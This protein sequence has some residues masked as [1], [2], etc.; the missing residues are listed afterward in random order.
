MSSGSVCF[1]SISL[2][3]LQM[4]QDLTECLESVDWLQVSIIR[5]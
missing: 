2:I 1:A 5:Q 3:I 4:V